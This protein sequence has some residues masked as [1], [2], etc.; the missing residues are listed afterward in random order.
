MCGAADSGAQAQSASQA[1]RLSIVGNLSRKKKR[2]KEANAT[3]P[4]ELSS[5]TRLRSFP[6]HLS[7]KRKIKRSQPRCTRQLLRLIDNARRGAGPKTKAAPRKER[8]GRA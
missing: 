6:A 2:P 5:A 3:Y 7:L 4:W 8:S 1:R